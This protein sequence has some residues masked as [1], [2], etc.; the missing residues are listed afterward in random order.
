M[1]MPAMNRPP[2]DD[3]GGGGAPDPVAE[4]RGSLEQLWASLP[5]EAQ[6]KLNPKNPITQLLFKRLRDGLAE[7]E[8]MALLDLFSMADRTQIAALRKVF[9]E[10][11]ILLDI[12]DDGIVNDS[13]GMLDGSGSPEPQ[14]G[15]GAPGAPPPAAR[16]APPRGG[17][18]PGYE[19]EEDEEEPGI[20]G[21][22]ALSRLAGVRA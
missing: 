22:G 15:G 6:A 3:M 20:G 19:E 11:I 17:P 10:I 1:G 21:A 14:T 13:V 4:F 8:G 2:M 18:P 16:P 9:P 5:P 7:E 12:F